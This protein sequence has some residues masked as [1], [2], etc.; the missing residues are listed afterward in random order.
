MAIL[1]IGLMA[2]E[3][4]FTAAVRGRSFSRHT[5]IKVS[6]IEAK[7][8]KVILEKGSN[9]SKSDQNAGSNIG[10]YDGGCV[11]EVAH[12]LTHDFKLLEPDI[13]SKKEGVQ[14]LISSGKIGESLLGS[15]A[16]DE[17]LLPL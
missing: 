7:V 6:G 2:V 5:A 10:F 1:G 14:Q 4:D 8:T 17:I 3:N 13:K 15:M 11:I 12:C 9:L 16:I